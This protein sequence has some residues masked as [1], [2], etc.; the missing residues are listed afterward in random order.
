MRWFFP[1]L[2]P[3]LRP[4]LPAPLPAPLPVLAVLAALVALAPAGMVA[5]EADF[6]LQTPAMRASSPLP[7]FARAGPVRSFSDSGAS[8]AGAWAIH[9]IIPED[10]DF[11]DW[12][13]LFAG[14]IEED[15]SLDMRD[16]ITGQFAVYARACGSTPEMYKVFDYQGSPEADEEQVLFTILCPAYRDD[17]ERGEFVVMAAHRIG[18][19]FL[20][21]YQHWRGPAYDV[22]KPQEWP[23]PD[24]GLAAFLEVY[25]GH[26]FGPRQ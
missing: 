11:D 16:Y 22:R 24:A 15:L 21:F 14:L 20:R 9:E 3:A 6:T 12:T 10:Q 4:T 2:R 19:D 1:T 26:G 8:A 17:P 23:V 18:N 5:G 7:A 25:R 13:T